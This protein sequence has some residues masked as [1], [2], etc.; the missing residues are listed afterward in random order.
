VLLREL[1]RLYGR[2]KK[3]WITE[4]GYQTRP[5]DYFGIPPR[6]QS[7]FLREAYAI[8]KRNRRIDMLV[9]FLLRDEASRPVRGVYGLPGWQ[10]GL[11]YDQRTN[12]GATKPAFYRFRCL[13]TRRTATGC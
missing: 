13:A 5:P 9:W 11:M 10:S 3:L 4:Y 2:G 8:A 12:G 1:G 6:R 7:V